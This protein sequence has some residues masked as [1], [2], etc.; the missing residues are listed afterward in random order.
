MKTSEEMARSVLG[1]AK[2][3]RA[4]QK[5][6]LI[7]GTL[8]FLCVCC[9]GAGVWMAGRAPAKSD[10]TLQV[11]PSVPPQTQPGTNVQ[12]QPVKISLLSYAAEGENVVILKNGIKTP[13][14]GQIRVKDIRGMTEDEIQ[15]AYEAEKEYGQLV[16]EQMREYFSDSHNLYSY[17]PNGMVSSISAGCLVVPIQDSSLVEDVRVTVTGNGKL[18]HIE[19]SKEQQSVFYVES[20]EYPKEYVAERWHL[21]N[22]GVVM[23][24]MLSEDM[25]WKLLNDPTI[26][27]TTITSTIT[28]TMNMTDGIQVTSVVDVSVDEEGFVYFTS[29]SG[30]AF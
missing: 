22:G 30:T 8:A 27:L 15:A 19:P 4:A 13:G 23:V 26:P 3:K 10:N 11:Q 7:T 6:S 17:G 1:R 9:I 24:W 14:Q 2:A 25:R 21:R 5:R 16:I 28:T 20:D 18:G 12:L 29:R